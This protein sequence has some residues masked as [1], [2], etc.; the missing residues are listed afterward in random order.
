MA[1]E[2]KS[3]WVEVGESEEL[4]AFLF[5]VRKKIGLKKSVETESYQQLNNP[6][7]EGKEGVTVEQMLAAAEGH[8]MDTKH[9]KDVAEENRPG[10]QSVHAGAGGDDALERAGKQPAALP[11]DCGFVFREI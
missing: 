7:D 5:P 4:K 8:T 11:G 10:G 1:D 9:L 2:T 6:E 3:D